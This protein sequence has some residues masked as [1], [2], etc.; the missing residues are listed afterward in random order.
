KERSLATKVFVS[1]SCDASQS[2]LARDLKR[3]SDLSSK[4]TAD[5]DM[6]DLLACVRTRNKMCIVAIDF[7]M[8]T[9]NCKDFGTVL[10]VKDLNRKI[11][12]HKAHYL[13]FV[14]ETT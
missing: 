3:R 8:L 14:L 11:A 10:E 4:V 12:S 7:A 2:Q 13:R 1:A 6:Q 9:T 5:G